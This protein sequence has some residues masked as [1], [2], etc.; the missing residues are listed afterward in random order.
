MEEEWKTREPMNARHD[1]KQESET[2]EKNV[3]SGRGRFLFF[4]SF[5]ILHVYPDAEVVE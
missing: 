5:A 2:S 3:S 1:V 4:S